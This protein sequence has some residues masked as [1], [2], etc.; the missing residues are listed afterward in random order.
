M[1]AP[2]F[3]QY[4]TQ[5]KWPMLLKPAS[6]LYQFGGY[7]H[8]NI[9]DAEKIDMPVICIGNLTV[10]GA[11]KT[12][13]CLELGRRLLAR[14]IKPAYLSR[15]YGGRLAGPLRVHPDEHGNKDVGDEPLLL[16]Q[17]SDAWIARHRAEGARAIYAADRSDLIIMDDGFQNPT[18]HKDLRILVVDGGYG[19]GNGKLLPAGPLRESLSS[20]MARVHAV[21]IIGEDLIGVADQLDPDIPVFQAY[22]HTDD[23]HMPDPSVPYVAFAGIGRPEKFFNTLEDLGCKLAQTA[24]FPD[25]WPYSRENIRALK[26]LAER[27]EARLITTEKDWVRIPEHQRDG[28]FTLP[29]SLKWKGGEESIES[30]IDL[31]LSRCELGQIH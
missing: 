13:V 15:G 9:K 10:G 24:A 6:S 16:A 28:I 25:H 26:A 14:G 11:G 27:H 17:M 30:L 22:F 2:K 29:V 31:I 23:D 1:K 8:R 5:S 7:I 20:G 3:W 21:L 18:I 4:G 19:F 12:P